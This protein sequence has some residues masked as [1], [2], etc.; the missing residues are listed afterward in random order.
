MESILFE[1]K[2]KMPYTDVKSSDP[3][4]VALRRFKRSCEKAGI[5][6]ELR[7]REF[8]EK[9]TAERKRKHAAAVK[10][11][12]KKLQKEREHMGI[13]RVERKVARGNNRRP[14]SAMAREA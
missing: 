4:E 12:E 2:D 8:Y 5:F 10:R 13:G 7:K 3:F 1:V 6:G 14:Y 9:P 11:W